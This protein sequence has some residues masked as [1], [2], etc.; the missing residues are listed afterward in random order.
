MLAVEVLLPSMIMA[1]QS[2]TSGMGRHD[3][4][5]LAT[6]VLGAQFGDLGKAQAS[7]VKL[8]NLRVQN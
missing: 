6:R 7:E 4:Q 3:G 1:A 2:G 5:G 8:L